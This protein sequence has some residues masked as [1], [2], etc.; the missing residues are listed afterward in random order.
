MV[1]HYVNPLVGP[2]WYTERIKYRPL[3]M[4]WT[5]ADSVHQLDRAIRGPYISSNIILGVSVK[6]L[7]DEVNTCISRLSKED[8]PLDLDG[9]HQLGP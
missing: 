7:L 1:Y 8:S 3:A 5:M 9:S 6:V 4:I 2:P